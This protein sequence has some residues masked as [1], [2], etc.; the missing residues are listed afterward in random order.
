[1][2]YEYA[3]NINEIKNNEETKKLKYISDE[4]KN[5]INKLIF[6][7]DVIQSIFAEVVLRFAL[8]QQYSFDDVN[9]KRRIWKTIFRRL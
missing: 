4:R 7:K 3:F 2:I 1:M 8:W 9:K 5:K 6:E